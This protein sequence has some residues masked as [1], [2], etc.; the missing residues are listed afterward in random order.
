MAREAASHFHYTSMAFLF[1]FFTLLL[2]SHFTLALIEQNLSPLTSTKEGTKKRNTMVDASAREGSTQNYKKDMTL[3]ES[4]KGIHNV[5]VQVHGPKRGHA[6]AP[7]PPLQWQKRIFNAS[8]H[9]VPSGPNPIA[10]R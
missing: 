3:R 1:F 2:V 8:E 4:G 9:E 6:R 7:R 5:P 10:N